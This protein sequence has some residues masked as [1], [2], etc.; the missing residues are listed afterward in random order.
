MILADTSGAE[1]SAGLISKKI[2]FL[3][4]APHSYKPPEKLTPKNV[5][6][7][8]ETYRAYLQELGRSKASVL[9]HKAITFLENKCIVYENGKFYC[10]PLK[11]YNTR[12][13][14]LTCNKVTEEWDCNCQ[15]A[16]LKRRKGEPIMCSHIL[17]LKLWFK[18]RNEKTN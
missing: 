1:T 13:Y 16:Q 10:L 7:W 2:S 3:A 11:G 8:S 18:M 14:E 5:C 6:Y 15:G 12:T 17:A 9:K 4:S